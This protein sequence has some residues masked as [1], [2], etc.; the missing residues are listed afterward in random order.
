M[1]Y[2]VVAERGA[3][4]ELGDVLHVGWPHDAL[5]VDRHVHEELV[6]LDVLLG[7]RADQVVVRHAGDGKHWLAVQLRVV[8]PIGEVNAAGAGGR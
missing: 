1:R 7:I 6:K 2:T 5:V 3:T 8:Q 4:R